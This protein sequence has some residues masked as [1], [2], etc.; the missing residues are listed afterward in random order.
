[1]KRLTRQGFIASGGFNR[2]DTDSIA[3]HI[4]LVALMSF[5]L[6][7]ELETHTQRKIDPNRVAALALVHD[8][9]ESILGDVNSEVKRRYFTDYGS[10]EQL[11]VKDLLGQLLGGEYLL[12]LCHEFDACDTTAAKIVRLA[13]SLDAWQHVT[14][15]APETWMPQHIDYRNRT[16]RK[17][18]GD[19]IFGDSLAMLFLRACL[20]I[21][22]ESFGPKRS[23]TFR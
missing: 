17:I 3:D 18:Q 4:G 15:R 19:K 12:E 16:F 14:A 21:Q 22:G 5:T 1:L 2:W 8:L 11:A 9:G 23:I 10:T 20:V 6:A 13:D 7:L